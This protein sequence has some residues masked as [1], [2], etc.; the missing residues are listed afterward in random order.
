MV[1]NGACGT[2]QKLGGPLT[3]TGLRRGGAAVAREERQSQQYQIK[4]SLPDWQQFLPLNVI[5]TTPESPDLASAR[6]SDY[7]TSW[8]RI[9]SCVDNAYVR[10]A[11][12]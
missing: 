7:A 4:N 8:H 10:L 9:F 1:Q 2:R 3:A 5:S 11:G 6:V 12:G